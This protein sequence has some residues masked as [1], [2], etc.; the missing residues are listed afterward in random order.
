MKLKTIS[1]YINSTA[2]QAFF[3]HFEL[4]SKRIS[5]REFC[6][7][8]HVF[9]IIYLTW[10]AYF[11]RLS[12]HPSVTHHCTSWTE[13]VTNKPSSGSLASED[14]VW[15]FPEILLRMEFKKKHLLKTI[16]LWD[17]NECLKSSTFVFNCYISFKNVIYQN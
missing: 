2:S 16:K 12:K 8:V 15:L 7:T 3:Y 1:Q 13:S 14:L 9:L 10:L 5:T 11:P 6:T 4:D 17:Q